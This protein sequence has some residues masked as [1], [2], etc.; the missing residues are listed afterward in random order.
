MWEYD[1]FVVSGILMLRVVKRV[2]IWCDMYGEDFLNEERA[3]L[4]VSFI[5]Q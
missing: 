3:W 5:I 2:H 1:H 4:R